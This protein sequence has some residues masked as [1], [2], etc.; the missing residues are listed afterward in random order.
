[1]KRTKKQIAERKAKAAEI[2]AMYNTVANGG[3]MQFHYSEKG[4]MDDPGG[5]DLA[6][7]LSKYRVIPAPKKP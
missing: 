7:N 3:R 4:W 2:A 6:S 1:M 5:P